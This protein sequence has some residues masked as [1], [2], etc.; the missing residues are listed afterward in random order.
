MDIFIIVTLLA[1]LLATSAVAIFMYVKAKDRHTD[2]GANQSFM[3]LQNQIQELGRLLDQKMGDTHRLVN[4]SQIKM[5]QSVQSQIT[6]SVRVI[7]GIT[8]KMTKLDETNKQIVGFAEQLQ[9]LENTLQNPKHRGILGEYYLE[10]VIK[11]VLPP[12]NYELQ[13]R[14][15]NGDIV[16][17]AVF[18]KDKIIPIDSKFSLENYNR[19]VN[20]K[21]PDKL[22]EL[23]TAF[24]RDLKNRIDETAKYIKPKEGTMDFAFMFIPAEGIY[25][26]L[27]INEGG[28]L[29]TNTR[30][31][32]EYA[33]RE[34]R[35]IIVSPSSF[36]AYLQTVLQGLRALQIEESAKEIRVRVEDLGRH[37]VAFDDYLKKM[38][39]HL[40]TTV[41]TYN[42]AYKEFAKIDKD[43][44][45]IG[46]GERQ[47]E[48]VTIDKPKTEDEG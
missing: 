40:T 17:A 9:N 8:E 11:N 48:A 30:D 28:P 36:L 13:Y 43:V 18:V 42:Q 44:M 23:E 4:D 24:K 3:L 29:K 45:K 31:L 25:Y 41:N 39:N 34:K 1:L 38:G 33:F 7:A 2:P 20:E 19:L 6:E 12:G 21:N 35:V 22:L 37:M 10:T 16:D 26:D 32:I 46:G 15:A 5:H 14:F 27:V 47:I